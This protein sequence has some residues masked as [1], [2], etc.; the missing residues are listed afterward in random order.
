[1]LKINLTEAETAHLAELRRDRT[2]APAERSRVEMVALSGEGWSAPKIARHLHVNPETV[3]R[4][5][6]RWPTE[7]FAAVKLQPPG[8]PPDT[9]W[10]TKV[11][12]ALA[13][14]IVQERVWT[15][16]QLAEDLRA[17]GF[18]ISEDRTRHYLHTLGARW[19]RLKYRLKD[20][21]DA[22]QV[23]TARKDLE[24]FA[25]SPKQAS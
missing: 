9:A 24:G 11:E 18:K 21:Q 10:Q 22:V 17:N 2:L 5:L 19:I 8:P 14:R 20:K 12:A 13:E 7:G 16:A 25:N 6:R 15:A 1:M 3:R 23:E 4:F